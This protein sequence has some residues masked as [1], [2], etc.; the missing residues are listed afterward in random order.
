[1]ASDRMIGE[2]LAG[3]YLLEE[4]IATGSTSVI[5]RA[6]NKRLDQPV[7]VKVL[8]GS[9]TNNTTLMARFESEAR[10]QAKLNHPHI[11]KVFDFV[12]DGD[13]Y[14]IVMEL[15][16]GT[17]L[18]QML[19]E[20]AGP[21]DL[22]RI[23]ALIIQVLDAV[24]Y[25]HS[26]GIVHRDIKPS[27]IIV[28]RVGGREF[29]KVMDFGIAKVLAEGPSQT[30]PGAML[31]TLLFMSPEQCKAMNTVD[32]RADIY[33]IGVT[34]YQMTTGMVPFY[35]ESAF[36]I[37]LAHVQTPPTPPKEFIPDLP[38]EW[39]DMVL[40][41]LAKDPEARYQSM[42]ELSQA[43]R[44]IPTGGTHDALMAQNGPVSDYD[45]N[46][47]R[48]PTQ[49]GPAVSSPSNLSAQP[50][51][52]RFSSADRPSNGDHAAPVSGGANPGTNAVNSNAI[53]SAS[54]DSASV[55][56]PSVDSPSVDSGAV[57][58]ERPPE[59]SGPSGD[60]LPP[61]S[62]PGAGGPA[63]RQRLLSTPDE[64]VPSL[65]SMSVSAATNPAR[66]E[67]RS[68]GEAKL[69]ETS[70]EPEVK[71]EAAKKKS[72]VRNPRP[73]DL[74]N[75]D[76]RR[77]PTGPSPMRS[78]PSTD[79]L[80]NERVRRAVSR[81]GDRRPN[82]GIDPQFRR[83]RVFPEKTRRRRSPTSS[84]PS[85][86]VESPTQVLGLANYMAGAQRLRLR[87]PNKDD[88][89]RF[90]DPNIAGGG[91]FCPS[92]DPPEVGTA[93]RVEITFIGGPRFFVRGAV[94]WR[95]PQ[96]NDP[97]A[98]AG[99]GVQLHPSERGKLNY[100]NAWVHGRVDDK[101]GLRRLPL[102]LRVTYS[103]RSGRRINFTRDLNEEGIFVRSRELLEP[104]TRIRLTLMPPGQH[105]AFHLEGVV[106]R[107]VEDREDRGMG[108]RLRFENDAQRKNYVALIER[109]ENQFLSGELSDDVLA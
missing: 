100:V 24:G 54:V 93:V 73:A 8:Y 67:H 52:Q 103:G 14:A 88:W 49:V 108:I 75:G 44:L 66:F 35:A 16:Q 74:L 64:E 33:S 27:N 102:R 38:I 31:G 46:R 32:A 9:F 7:A 62:E 1:M 59:G 95:R 13:T 17:P 92:N 77:E 78:V 6:I 80:A 48:T 30:A 53:N 86:L 18:D 90:F 60:H 56:S 47:R 87:V 34:L 70:K 99:V 39:Q 89:D 37:M 25:A 69:P 58:S 91:I 55:D 15:A 76:F 3:V 40:R 98:R 4:E 26:Q 82:G 68:S 57:N 71:R 22:A 42:D 43:M 65:D 107:L 5:Y 84:H 63:R 109:L 81:G 79:G 94:T 45:A 28:S 101:R 104:E 41:C 21:M 2:A 105:K 51:P 10:V 36:E 50:M 61:S 72:P 20:L 19:Y 29:P 12:A 96:L 23:K 83:E 11:V 97:R 106:S 85:G